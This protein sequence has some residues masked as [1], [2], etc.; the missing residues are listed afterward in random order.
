MYIY[1]YARIYISIDIYIYIHIESIHRKVVV[2]VDFLSCL[3]CFRDGRQTAQTLK[4]Y[5]AAS[6]CKVLSSHMNYRRSALK[7][8]N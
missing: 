7:M 8:R 1:K 3:L 6:D 4:F 2:G 5:E